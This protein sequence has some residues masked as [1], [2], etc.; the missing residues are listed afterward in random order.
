M[1]LPTVAA[2]VIS[3]YFLAKFLTEP[4]KSYCEGKPL[5]KW[6]FYEAGGFIC[7]LCA[8]AMVFGT[9]MQ[10]YSDAIELRAVKGSS[11]QSWNADWGAK[12]PWSDK[13][14]II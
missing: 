9:S 5:L 3:W 13:V 14:P 11:V 6:L 4:T 12:D 10:L 1:L 7:V 2:L 8:A